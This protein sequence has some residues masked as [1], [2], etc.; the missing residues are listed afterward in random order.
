MI[1]DHSSLVE[2]KM[3]VDVPIESVC[4][5]HLTDHYHQ[6]RKEYTLVSGVLLAYVLIGIG[7]PDDGKLI[8]NASISL[9]NPNA[10]PIIFLT[11][12]IYFSY[13]VT[14]EWNQCDERRRAMTVSRVDFLVAHALGLCSV[15]AYLIDRALQ[16]GLGQLVVTYAPE[17]FFVLL[18]LAICIEAPL[19]LRAAIEHFSGGN[20]S[21][22]RHGWVGRVEAS[23]APIFVTIFCVALMGLTFV[24]VLDSLTN[25][26]SSSSYYLI[27]NIGF[28]VITLVAL[29]LPRRL[30][31][32]AIPSV[33]LSLAGKPYT[34]RDE[35]RRTA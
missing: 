2:E 14:I 31:D 15:A 34:P 21:R 8:P 22:G 3:L 7:L 18:W 4:I 13:R 6:A 10:L 12:L 23:M 20:G 26:A 29:F 33:L 28:A 17:A 25:L 16:Y 19:L 30:R 24:L 27:R 9:K 1:V 11:L 5:P 35:I 32:Q